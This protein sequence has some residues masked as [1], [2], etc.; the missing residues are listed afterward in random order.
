MSVEK[1]QR[2][3]KGRPLLTKVM[4]PMVI[5]GVLQAVVFIAIMLI[6]GEMTYIE[7]YS[8]DFLI[9]KTS[10]RAFYME[11]TLSQ[12]TAL[13]S[14]EASDISERI[15]TM[16]DERGVSAKALSAD[17]DVSRDI[18]GAVSPDLI[19]LMRANVV[20]DA[21]IILETGDL[22]GEDVRPGVYF[23]D[24]DAYENSETGYA[25]ISMEMG[26]VDIAHSIGA[27][28]DYEWAPVLDMSTD[29]DFD[30]YKVPMSTARKYGS[31]SSKDLGYWSVFSKISHFSQPSLKY[32]VPLV[33]ASGDVYGVMGIGLL[34]K[35]ILDSIPQLDFY[36][37][38]SCYILGVDN[39]GSGEYIPIS[40]SGSVF[41]RLQSENPTFSDDGENQYGL[42]VIYS[43]T[44][45]KYLSSF[46]QIALYGSNS[47][48]CDQKWA[49]ISAVRESTV[50]SIYHF[51]FKLAVIIFA[52]TL[53]IS[54]VFAFV[55]SR[56]LSV[57]VTRM[58]KTLREIEPGDKSVKFDS[59]GVAEIDELASS[60]TTLQEN[61]YE[62]A[63]RVSDIINRTNSGIGIFMIDNRKKTVFAGESLIRITGLELPHRDI[64]V[65]VEEFIAAL[66]KVDT[67]A[68]LPDM[69]VFIGE[70]MENRI[71][72]FRCRV[73]GEERWF[74]FMAS[75]ISGGT[76]GVVQDIS[77]TVAEKAEIA[78]DKDD[79]YTEK[80]LQ[81]NR[82]LRDAYDSA[83][84]ANAAK[85]EFLSRMS[86]DIRTPMNAIIGMTTIAEANI[87]DTAKVSDCLEKISGSG[88]YLLSLI[89]EVLDMSRIESGGFTLAEDHFNISDMLDSLAEMI[90]PSA[91][92]KGHQL[93]YRNHD[94]QHANVSADKLRL[95]QI[96]MNIVG[97]SIKYTNPGGTITVDVTE[98]EFN[99][100][101]IA[102][103]VFTFSDNGIGMSQEF[104]G[105][106][107]EPFERASDE[108][109]TQEQGTGLGM[110][111]T[112]NIVKMMGG[113]ITV[114]S[115]LGK[116]STFVV[117]LYFKT[118]DEKTQ[119][120]RHSGTDDAAT[121]KR[122]DFSGVRVL[123]VDDNEL[124]REIVAELFGMTKLTVD[125]AVNGKDAVDKFASSVPGYY[126]VIFMDV[127]MP[128][129]DGYEAT[130]EI[131]KL[132]RPD[133]DVP[134]FAMTANAFSDDIRNSLSC[135][136]NEHLAKPIDVNRL[137][138]V[139]NKWVKK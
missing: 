124:N 17:K 111:I 62:Y 68:G 81:A 126:S 106:I 60:V 78:R 72:E 85:T 19:A 105:R 20:N 87:D 56:V 15:T 66:D 28:L 69:D 70:L 58:I 97:N 22:Y 43:N 3:R 46:R 36:N 26:S 132:D 67:D 12:K 11:N 86:H 7:K 102:C 135:G 49:M 90:T 96:F 128:V 47:P 24:T 4:L 114:M 99:K 5:L 93:I 9:E 21:F 6:S 71:S 123:L 117:T 79:E 118:L 14:Q 13:A 39:D 29:N 116:G 1:R 137:I 84:H 75:G 74:K 82:A 18:L 119:P 138:E 37:E 94:I 45:V 110:A 109:V 129:M 125:Q 25:D 121:L 88:Q 133:N 136:M 55:T 61:T 51:M 31:T 127:Q 50:M 80:L 130:R 32:S 53:V 83:K 113:D 34:E 41:T 48:Y 40:H 2:K 64:T 104:L 92:A 42:S 139:M 89:N 77:V 8:S 103:Y 131:R 95:Q 54:V 38:D 44:G 115:E 59:S 16:L 63:F 112:Y 57:P 76:I 73:N 30:F 10:N 134:I 100:K 35:T 27:A 101:N 65:P 52:V 122:T 33:S 98:R 120:V 91:K 108:R 23:R 107:F